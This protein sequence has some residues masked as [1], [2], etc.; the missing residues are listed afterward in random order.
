MTV[1]SAQ[2]VPRTCGKTRMKFVLPEIGGKEIGESE[3]G[4]RVEGGR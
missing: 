1:L 4:G 3:I 2:L